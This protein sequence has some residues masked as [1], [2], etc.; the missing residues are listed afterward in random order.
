[1]RRRRGGV[2]RVVR[3]GQRAAR[4]RG[5]RSGRRRR[6]AASVGPDIG[7]AFAGDGHQPAPARRRSASA[8]SRDGAIVDPDHR[9][10]GRRLAVENLPLGPG[11][12]GHVAVAVEMVGAEVEHRRRIEAERCDSLQH[13]GGH[14]QH[15]DPVM[16]Q[17]R[18]RQGGGAE[19]AAR[20][21]RPPGRRQDMRQQRRGGGFAVGAGDAGEPRRANPPPRTALEQQVGI[22]QDR[23]PGGAA[24]RAAIGCGFGRP[25][26]M[27]GD[28]T[29]ASSPAISRLGDRDAGG[30][31]R[32]ARRCACRPRRPP[33]RPCRAARSAA[34]RPF[35]PSPTHGEAPAREQIG[36]KASSDF[37]G[38]QPD[39]GKNHGD[40]P[41]ADDDGRFL[42]SLSS[43]NDGA[44][45]PSGTRAVRCA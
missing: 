8:I 22:R 29:S 34:G 37:Q 35:L 28:S 20:R 24:P 1:M 33:R 40:D 36:G 21:D 12:A 39:Q 5:R 18:Q 30:R 23:H 45:A 32:F 16:G 44:A 14:F 7:R 11:I 43:R 15:V 26:G 25:C 4:R 42:P 3:A 10:V 17:Q 9:G 27:P 19:I 31:G 13:V 6:A 38:P 41:E 2:L